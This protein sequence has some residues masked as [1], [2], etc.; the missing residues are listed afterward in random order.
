MVDTN[1]APWH[2]P[3]P[4]VIPLCQ[5]VFIPEMICVNT[6]H[7]SKRMLERL[8]RREP[9]MKKSNKRLLITVIAVFAVFVWLIFG[10]W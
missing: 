6:L 7:F 8:R 5:G 3:A 4:L 2:S 9:I 10:S 1:P